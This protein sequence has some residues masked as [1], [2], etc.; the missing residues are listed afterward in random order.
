MGRISAP[1]IVKDWELKYPFFPEEHKEAVSLAS[2]IG[3]SEIL[4]QLLL[5]RGIVETDAALQ[6]LSKSDSLL[7]DPFLLAD[8]NKAVNRILRAVEDKEKVAIFG[9]Y[10]VDGITSTVVLYLY[11]RTLGCDVMYY[12]PSRISEGYGLTETSIQSLAEQNVKLIVTVDTGITAS[13]E[14][15]F[16]H[17][18]GIDVVVTDHHECHGEIPA[19]CA[20]VNPRRPDCPYPNKDLAGVGVVYKLISAVEIQRSPQEEA[21][22]CVRRV[23]L[24]YA[25]LIAI[26]TIADVMPVI[27]EN[28]LIISLGLSLLSRT[29]RLGLLSLIEAADSA[30]GSSKSQKKKRMTTGYVSY[31]IAPRL[32]AAGRISEATLAVRLLLSEHGEEARELAAQL[33]EINKYRQNEENKIADEA[34]EQVLTECD[35]TQDR[36]LVLSSETWHQGIIGIVASRVSERFGLPTI[37]ITFESGDSD[38]QIGKGS[39]RS[40]GKINLVE[41]LKSCSDTLVKF[42]GHAMAAGLSVSRE[43]LADFKHAINEYVRTTYSDDDLHLASV[44]DMELSVEDVTLGLAEEIQQLE[45]FGISNVLPQFLFSGLKVAEI[46]PIGNYRHTKLLLSSP[47]GASTVTGLCFGSSVDELDLCVGD[48][49]DILANLDINEFQGKKTVQLLIRDLSLE[50]SALRAFTNE[51]LEFEE[52]ISNSYPC[53]CCDIPSRE[54]FGSVYTLL[55]NMNA[56][57]RTLLGTRIVSARTKLSYCK[58]RVIFAVM[59]EF[60]LCSF[61]YE[62]AEVFR[63]TLTPNPTRADLS[64]SLILR[65]IQGKTTE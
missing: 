20:V 55:R 12:I 54:D 59:E 8:M 45:P 34:I 42:G 9:D 64:S 16:A 3:C 31:T 21:I 37:L 51:T 35:L 27:G 44:S 18:I 46:V 6:F 24:S 43:R 25:D 33:C 23:S 26:G 30:E 19:C 36:V 57:E 1:G 47:E 17:S 10:D 53:G 60:G 22:D 32:N 7:F 5:N 38:G 56:E 15:S 39:G 48:T 11:L 65:S 28:R 52:I 50:K 40:V 63:F 62:N 58:I 29:R 41:A 13:D 61:Q 49:I 2:R 14:C 4:A